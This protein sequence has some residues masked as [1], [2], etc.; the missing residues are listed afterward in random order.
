[1]RYLQQEFGAKGGIRLVIGA[2]A[3]PN[4]TYC[5]AWPPSME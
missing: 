1:M 3:A 2:W 5:A 4:P